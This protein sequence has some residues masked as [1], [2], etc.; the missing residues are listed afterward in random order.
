MMRNRVE[1][2][3]PFLSRR[4][5]E[6]ALALARPERTGKK[7]LRDLFRGDLPEGVADRP[8]RAL[9]TAT[10][11]VNREANSTMLVD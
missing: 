9:R 2:R 11:E 6:M 8:K 1:V 3:S 10:I 4:V 7:V 5:A